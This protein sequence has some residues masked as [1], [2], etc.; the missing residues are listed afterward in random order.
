VANAQNK[1]YTYILTELSN[2]GIYCFSPRDLMAIFGLTER[3]AYE[4]IRVLKR[5]R[6]IAMVEKGKNLLLGFAP[7]KALG[8][9][10]YI[11][12]S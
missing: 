1:D 10:F 3:Q 4:A 12:T 9:P 7:G 2:K 8:N 11:A 5:H 6:L